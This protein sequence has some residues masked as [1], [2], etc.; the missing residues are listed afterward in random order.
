MTTR[1]PPR[2][3][4]RP[5][6]SPQGDAPRGRRSA[7]FAQPPRKA[8]PKEEEREDGP[9]RITKLLARAGVGSR[10]DVER[11]IEEGR[12]ALNGAVIGQPAP[13]LSSLEG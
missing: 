10:R 2:S 3:P 4:S 7:R 1:R 5:P 9:Q 6:A 13:L 11:M 8:P 12:I